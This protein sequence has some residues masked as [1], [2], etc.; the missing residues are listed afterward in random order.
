MLNLTLFISNDG[1]LRFRTRLC[2]PDDGEIRRELLEEAHYSRLAVHPEGTKMYK[3]L[4]Q[5]YLWLGMKRD[6]AQFVV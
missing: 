5:N 4:K 6:I 1:I 3:A 2:V